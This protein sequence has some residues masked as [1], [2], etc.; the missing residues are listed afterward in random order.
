MDSKRM[1]KLYNTVMENSK[2]RIV[3]EFPDMDQGLSISAVVTVS[4]DVMES[5]KHKYL[6]FAFYYRGC[7]KTTRMTITPEICKDL[8]ICKPV[9]TDMFNNII[10]EGWSK[11]LKSYTSIESIVLI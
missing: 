3:M 2:A 1:E 11:V 4:I 10:S 6:N 8:T 5:D 9:L 7:T